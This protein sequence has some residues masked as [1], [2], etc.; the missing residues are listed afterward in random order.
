MH[1]EIWPYV[2]AAMDNDNLHD[3]AWDYTAAAIPTLKREAKRRRGGLRGSDAGRCVLEVCGDI[4]ELSERFDAETAFSR[5]DLGSL[6]GAHAASLFKAG[7]EAS[8]DALGYTVEVEAEGEYL[9]VPCHIDIIMLENQGLGTTLVPIWTCEVKTNYRPAN[10][11]EPAGQHP[12][13][14]DERPEYVLQGAHGAVSKNV[15]FFSVFQFAPAAVRR[16][17]NQPVYHRQDDYLTANWLYAVDQEYGGRLG[18]A[19]GPNPP[20]CDR[21]GK[22]EA[23]RKDYCRMAACPHKVRSNA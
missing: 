3:L 4:H 2:K 20:R 18:A 7:F 19:T 10:P 15:E 1:F 21:L 22:D 17:G 9:G 13:T 8:E 23:W 14:D 6:Y 11:P 12:S 16:G 5:L